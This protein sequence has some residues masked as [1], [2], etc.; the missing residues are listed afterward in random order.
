MRFPLTV[1]SLI[2]LGFLAA[3]QVSV[4]FSRSKPRRFG[5]PAGSGGNEVAKLLGNVCKDALFLYVPF[6]AVALMM[7]SYGKP[8]L[9]PQYAA[10]SIVALQTLRSGAL[11]MEQ[12]RLRSVFGILALI[13]LI[14]LWAWQLPLFDPI[15]A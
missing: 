3:W 9:L 13:C 10:W 11:V 1:M 15:P 6:A 7:I 12:Q 5:T 14:Y 8:G 2:V 4:L